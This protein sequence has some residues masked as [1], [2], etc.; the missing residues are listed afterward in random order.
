M[1]FEFATAGRILFGPGT[2][3]EVPCLAAGL[4]RR[5]CVFTDSRERCAWLLQ[6]LARQGLA[7]ALFLVEKE[8]DVAAILR[9][10]QAYEDAGC[11]LVIGLGGG[12][13]I[14]TG[15]AVAALVVNPQQPLHYL[16]VV[17][18]G[19]PLERPSVPYIAIPTTAGTGAEVTRN[20]VLT[21]PEKRVKV[22]LRSPFLLP[23]IAVVDPELTLSLPPALT[24]STGM[25]A[26]TQVLE[27]FVCNAPTPLTDAL[28]RDGIARAGQCL[29]RAYTHGDDL[30]ARQGMSLVS[31]YGGLALAN[32]RLGAV[33][34]LAGPLGGMYPAPHGAVCAR[35]L[36]L[37]MAANV[38]ALQ[39]RQPDSPTLERYAEAARLLTGNPAARAEDGIAY[40]AELCRVM[41]IHPLGEFGLRAEDFPALVQQ[42]QQS[43][44]MKGNPIQLTDAEVAGILAAVV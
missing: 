17:G 12:A 30:A 28:C 42:A 15:K 24:A 1:H 26:L 16:E 43:S 11:D 14:D 34:G 4:G 36:P 21:V 5:A 41:S 19:H 32:A 37:V 18:G 3:A 8:P 2:A 20:A 13:V 9:L 39:S 33:H 10:T 44:S 22:S 40:A 6:G 23:R 38:H 25:D 7:T 35:L 29:P 31:L 27:P